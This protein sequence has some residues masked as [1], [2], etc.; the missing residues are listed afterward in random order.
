M[1]DFTPDQ[2]EGAIAEAIRDRDFPA[3][4]SL[5]KLLAVR[6]PD[7]AQA[8]LDTIEMARVMNGGI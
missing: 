2:I 3:V 6:A 5:L 8:V 4:V 1:A 7:R